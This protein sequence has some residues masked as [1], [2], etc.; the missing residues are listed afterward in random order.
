M[1]TIDHIHK[2]QLR[3]YSFATSL[4]SMNKIWMNLYLLSSEASEDDLH[5]DKTIINYF[6]ADIYEYDK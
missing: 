3:N 2:W 5:K 6:M 4:I 1:Q